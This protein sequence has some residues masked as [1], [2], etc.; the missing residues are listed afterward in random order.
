M[1]ACMQICMLCMYAYMHLFQHHHYPSSSLLSGSHG[2][3]YTVD[4][5]N[6]Q[7]LKGLVEEGRK[8]IRAWMLTHA[9]PLPV[10][11]AF[12]G[13]VY[14]AGFKHKDLPHA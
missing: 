5:S 7:L 11:K 3:R 4:R 12:D 6:E 14:K 1:H 8:K 2:T 13:D 10:L 9:V